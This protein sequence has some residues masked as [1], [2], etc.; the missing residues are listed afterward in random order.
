MGVARAIVVCAALSGGCSAAG[1]PAATAGG[2]VAADDLGV[3]PDLPQAPARIACAPPRAT[4]VAA[5]PSALAAGDLEGDGRVD[6]FVA[7][8]AAGLWQQLM[9]RGDGSFTVV[10]PM[11]APPGSAPTAV[12][13]AGPGSHGGALAVSASSASTTVTLFD[14]DA[15]WRATLSTVD[16]WNGNR[17]TSIVTGDLDGDGYVDLLAGSTTGGV[18][19]WYGAA[20][21]LVPSSDYA[22]AIF[23]VADFD[24]DGVA[25]FVGANI[26]PQYFVEIGSGLPSGGFG[27]ETWTADGHIISAAAGDFDGDGRPDLVTADVAGD[28]VAVRRNGGGAKLGAPS[29]LLAGERPGPLEVADFD[30]DGRL[31]VA[32]VEPA[33]DAVAVLLGRGDGTFEAPATCGVGAGPV[34]LAVGD[35][36]GDGRPDL[37]TANGGAR[38]VTVV[39]LR[40]AP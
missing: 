15:A 2:P 7:S 9:G 8:A 31:D 29:A 13:I 12:A 36:D 16:G 5:A 11:L 1:L 27:G 3:A 10:A 14:V 26:E 6:L 32:A 39:L 19:A 20:R 25:D 22:L 24:G 21:T 34:A 17:H 35:F 28:T 33:R 18:D 30:G 4:T 38:D 40:P 37:A 23:A